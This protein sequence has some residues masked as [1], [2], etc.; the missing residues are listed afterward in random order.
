MAQKICNCCGQLKDLTEFYKRGSGERR[1]TCAPC[2]KKRKRLLESSPELRY[3][4]YKR[5]AKRRELSFD[6]SLTQFKQFENKPCRYCGTEVSP[7]SLDRID[8]DIGYIIDNVDS[9]CFRCN[10][11]KHVFDEYDFLSHITD[12]YEFQKNKQV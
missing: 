4:I 12:I 7:I 10:S 11:L 1:A 6:L 9:C 2:Y 5:S 8:N 3:K